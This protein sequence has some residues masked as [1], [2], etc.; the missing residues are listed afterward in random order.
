[1]TEGSGSGFFCL[2]S[3]LVYKNLWIRIQFVLRGRIRIRLISDRIRNP[4]GGNAVL[5]ILCSIALS[6]LNLKLNT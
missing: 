1:M 4:D 2:D 6:E 3:D 5:F